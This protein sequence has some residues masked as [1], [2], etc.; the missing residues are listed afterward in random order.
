MSAPRAMQREE[1]A[2]LSPYAIAMRVQRLGRRGALRVSTDEITA[3]AGRLLALE[4]IA[5]S[6]YRLMDAL[7][8]MQAA[9]ADRRAELAASARAL[10]ETL[11]S[12]LAA[13]G[14]DTPED[15]ET[16]MAKI[17]KRATNL[18]VPQSDVDAAA[19][20]ARIGELE[21]AIALIEADG[22]DRIAAIGADVEAR[23][24]PLKEFLEAERSG[25]EIYCAAHRARL[26]DGGKSKTARFA[27]G[28]VS[29]RAL[30]PKVSLPRAREALAELIARLKAMRL[31]R[32][33]RVKEE[34]D[35]EAMLKEPEIA[36][37]VQGV[38]IGSAG[39]DFSVEP[40]E[41]PASAHQPAEAAS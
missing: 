24:T 32:F 13:L 33:L 19:A 9:P 39:E 11:A 35:K 5:A 1:P 15:E 17:K 3:V 28:S 26:T 37:S 40:L 22:S 14:Y 29:W 27:T 41:M 12:A 34:V 7:D 36:G 21:R 23:R 16:P 30:P 8:E 31:D 2:M 4:D 10:A 25:L 18:P 6:A 38:S 20:I